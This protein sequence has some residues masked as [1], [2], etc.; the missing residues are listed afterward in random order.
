MSARSWSIAALLVLAASLIP[1][2]AQPKIPSNELPGHERD[3]FIDRFPKPPRNDLMIAV[4][5]K[6]HTN[7]KCRTKHGTKKPRHRCR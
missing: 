7:R 4:P 2:Q 6:P 5:Q 3:R 1:A